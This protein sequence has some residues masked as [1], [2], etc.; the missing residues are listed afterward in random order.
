MNQ[1]IHKRLYVLLIATLAYIVFLHIGH[2]PIWV[3]ILSVFFGLWRLLVAFGKAK[4]TKL[5]VLA[6]LTIA[7]GVGILLTYKGLIY[8][9]SGVSMLLIMMMMKLL[10]AK[11]KHDY[12]LITILGYLLTGAI[13]FI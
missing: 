7:I 6:P 2:L 11:N 5:I 3:A 8:R 10:E 12:I 13:F 9:D 1:S 4:P